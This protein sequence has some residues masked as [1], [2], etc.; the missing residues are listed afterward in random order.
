LDHAIAPCRTT[1]GALVPCKICDAATAL[2]DVVDFRQDLHPRLYPR[3][4]RPCRC[5]TAVAMHADSLHRFFDDFAPQQW[6]AHA[7]TTTARSDPEYADQR[8]DDNARVVDRLLAPSAADDRLDWR[9]FR[10]H[11]PAAA[12]LG[13]RST[14]YPFGERSLTP[15]YAGRS[16]ARTAFEVAEHTPDPR[17]FVTRRRPGQQ[18]T[19]HRS[20][21]ARRHRRRGQPTV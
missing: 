3:A 9:R 14:P 15:E 8:P 12:R 2:F 20:A 11:L 4:W 5:T 10:S 21:P 19:G 13:W 16:G 17:G 7:T 18:T 1:A 6:G